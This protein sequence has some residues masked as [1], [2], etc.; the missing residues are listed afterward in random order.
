[1]ARVINQSTTAAL[2][3]HGLILTTLLLAGAA[4]GLGATITVT[5]TNDGGSG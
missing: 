4:G 5:N 3:R 2:F 1:M